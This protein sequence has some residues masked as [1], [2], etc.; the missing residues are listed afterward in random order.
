VVDLA[1]G[2][3][4]GAAFGTVVSSLVK[5]ILTPLL[6]IPGTVNFADLRAEV[7]GADILYGIFLNDLIAFLTI[8]VGVFFF[9]VRPINALMARRR[10]EPEVVSTTR[11]CPHCVSSIPV[12]A[13]VC[14]FCTHDVGSVV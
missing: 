14:A 6:A 10:T 13:S 11:S 12:D 7:G 1:V 8:A 9:V 3:V 5:N 2:I 4:I